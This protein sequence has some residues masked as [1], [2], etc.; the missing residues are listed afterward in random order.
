MPAAL[1]V[2][3]SCSVLL[4]APSAM[5]QNDMPMPGSTWG[6]IRFPSSAQP[7]E[8]DNILLNGAIEQ[9]VDFFPITK[10]TVI[11]FFGRVDYRWDTEEFDFNRKILLGV[12][13]KLR[14]YFSDTFV[15]SLGAKY[16]IDKRFVVE[17]SSDGILLFGQW[18]GSWHVPNSGRDPESGSGPLAYPGLTWGEIRYPGS[19]DPIEESS[20]V[21]E[22]YTE[23]GVD[24]AHW[25][26]WGTFN[27]YGNLD[28][29]VD[30]EEIEWNNLFAV[31]VGVKLKKLVGRN[32]LLQ[33]G[34]E[35]TRERYWVTDETLDVIFVYLNWSAWWDPRAVRRDLPD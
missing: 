17:R 4:G 3:L 33:Y 25:G 10:D 27:F 30:T 20:M 14:H 24:W 32:L 1:V 29:I 5:A 6:N 23:Q 16:E 11:N 7:A 22:G 21:F 35:A 12:G 18:F 2:L 15:M 31:G 26:R 28:Y 19:Q 9:G 13:F 34:I 8:S